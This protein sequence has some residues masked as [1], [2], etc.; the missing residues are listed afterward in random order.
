M[1]YRG[2]VFH[3]SGLIRLSNMRKMIQVPVDKGVWR[4]PSN[5]GST[6]A[7]PKKLM[8]THPYG[9]GGGGGGGGSFFALDSFSK[10]IVACMPQG[11]NPKTSVATNFL[12][13]RS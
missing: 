13:I 8:C 3:L 10:Y 5:G 11:K 4:S 7:I 1:I 12:D 9:G 2:E 6:V